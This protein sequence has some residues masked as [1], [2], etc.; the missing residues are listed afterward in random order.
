[1]LADV[2]K[3]NPM[4]LK[5]LKEDPDMKKQQID[6]LK[7]LLAFASQAQKSTDWPQNTTNKQELDNIRAEIDAVNYD[8]ESIKTRARCLRWFCDDDMV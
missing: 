5:K 7:Q 2:A 1:V 3:S 8:R 4:I 6:N